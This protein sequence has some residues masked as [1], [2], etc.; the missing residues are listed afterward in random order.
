M[1]ATLVSRRSFLGLLIATLITAL[2]LSRTHGTPPSPDC[3]RADIEHD[4]L[5]SIALC[6]SA[7]LVILNYLFFRRAGPSSSIRNAFLDFI[8]PSRV[9]R[10]VRRCRPDYCT[11]HS[12]TG[13]SCG[14]TNGATID[15]DEQL[16]RYDMASY[17][18]HWWKS[19]FIPGMGSKPRVQQDAER[20][21]QLRGS[22]M[23]VVMLR[24]VLKSSPSTRG[25]ARVQ[26]LV[27]RH[28]RMCDRRLCVLSFYS[29]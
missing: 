15:C 24:H 7:L 6:T 28:L 10:C 29:Y 4:V 11:S 2:R 27:E 9:Y 14:D 16:R 1:T 19:G 12:G 23:Y 18:R 20:R 3:A 26:D 25:S 22:H 17:G 5:D 13:R 21:R 8:L